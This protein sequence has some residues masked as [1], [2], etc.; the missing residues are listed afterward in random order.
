METSDE[1]KTVVH[2]LKAMLKTVR[3][4]RPGTEKARVAKALEEHLAELTPEALGLVPASE[5]VVEA[6]AS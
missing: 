3:S 2:H 5:S 6:K 1:L 4:V